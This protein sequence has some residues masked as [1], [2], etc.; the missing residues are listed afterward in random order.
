MSLT[1]NRAPKELISSDLHGLDDPWSDLTIEERTSGGKVYK[2]LVLSGRPVWL[3]FGCKEDGP[4]DVPFGASRFTR[5]G[6]T[7]PD[8]PKR[9]EFQFNLSDNDENLLMKLDQKI[10][11]LT[12]KAGSRKNFSSCITE[13]KNN[14]PARAR[15]KFDL[16]EG[17]TSDRDQPVVGVARDPD[18]NEKFAIIPWCKYK[19]LQ[20]YLCMKPLKA[21]LVARLNFY[22]TPMMFGVS[23]LLTHIDVLQFSKQMSASNHYKNLGVEL[24]EYQDSDDEQPANQIAPM[25]RVTSQDDTDQEDSVPLKNESNDETCSNDSTDHFDEPKP[26]RVKKENN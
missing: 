23:M 22:E 20:K 24:V 19:K 4:V 11:E 9:W 14:Y 13:A 1:T 21:Y 10:Q 6:N 15:T 26:K 8:N 5:P 25:K 16:Q 7:T 2:N 12:K 18:V 3:R 17:V